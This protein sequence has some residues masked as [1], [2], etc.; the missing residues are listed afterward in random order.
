M[1]RPKGKPETKDKSID[2]VT[3]VIGSLIVIAIVVVASLTGLLDPPEEEKKE[4]SLY[5]QIL[6]E[7]RIRNEGPW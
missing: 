3:A 4:R 1:I 7:D 6:E 5:E 2:P